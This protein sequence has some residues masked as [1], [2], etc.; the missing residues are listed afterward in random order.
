M[1]GVL[2]VAVGVVFVVLWVVAGVVVAVVFVFSVLF[3]FL[4][5][6]VLCFACFL[7]LELV[8][9]QRVSGF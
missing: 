1:L 2:V 3:L 7:V 9:G 4:L 8:V 6:R 5:V